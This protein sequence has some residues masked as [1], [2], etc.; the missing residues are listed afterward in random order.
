M[1]SRRLQERL[2]AAIEEG[3]QI[4]RETPD[5]VVLVRRSYGSVGIHILLAVFTAWWSF[6]VFNL[7]YAGYSYLEESER[8]VLREPS[9]EVCPECGAASRPGAEFCRECGADLD[10][11]AIGRGAADRG[12]TG[13]TAGEP[14]S[15][16]QCDAV[17]DDG[18]RYCPN[19]GAELAETAASRRDESNEG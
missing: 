11:G 1:H 14:R 7:L 19:C 2:D 6:A 3:W 15:C 16:P 4:E 18:D 17:V 5:R 10:R 9:E 8:R 13:E 12:A